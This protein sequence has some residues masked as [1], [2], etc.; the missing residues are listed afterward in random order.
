MNNYYSCANIGQAIRVQHLTVNLYLFCL[1]NYWKK[2]YIANCISF[3]P[4]LLW[5]IANKLSLHVDIISYMVFTPHRSDC[6][7]NFKSSRYLDLIMKS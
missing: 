1:V 7:V 6:S 3:Q 5:Y 4:N 2:S